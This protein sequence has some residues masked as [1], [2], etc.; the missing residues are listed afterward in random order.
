[1]QEL[2][3]K[4][5]SL[6]YLNQDYIFLILSQLSEAETSWH[7]VATKKTGILLFPAPSWRALFPGA[8]FQH[9][10]SCPQASVAEAKS[11]LSAINKWGYLSPQAPFV[12][13]RQYLGHDMLRVLGPHGP[14]PSSWSGGSMPGE[15]SSGCCHP[16][17]ANTQH[18]EHRVTQKESCLCPHP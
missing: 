5:E 6:C 11:W 10:L 2:G 7:I 16:Q 15:A 12:G 14:Y 4:N 13:W 3:K 1:M 18:L 17:P 9:F 8:R